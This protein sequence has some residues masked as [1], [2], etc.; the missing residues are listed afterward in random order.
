MECAGAMGPTAA[1]LPAKILDFEGF[2]SSR[3]LISRSGIP[4]PVG[5]FPESLSQAIL[6][7]RIPVGRSG[8]IMTI[9]VALKWVS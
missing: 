2:D 6:A 4:R 9:G 8:V 5:K 3:I 7:G 1:N